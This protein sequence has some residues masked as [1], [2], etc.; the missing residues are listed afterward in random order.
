LTAVALD[1]CGSDRASALVV[2]QCSQAPTDGVRS[3]S[4][5]TVFDKLV[6]LPDQT[7]V[8]ARN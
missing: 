7:V 6:N 4:H 2:N 5:Y 8:D 3:R 1:D